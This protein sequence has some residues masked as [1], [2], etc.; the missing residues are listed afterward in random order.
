MAPAEAGA[1]Q[2]QYLCFAVVSPTRTHMNPRGMCAHSRASK[3]ILHTTA[4]RARVCSGDGQRAAGDGAEGRRRRRPDRVA[5]A[6]LRNHGAGD[7]SGHGAKGQ[8]GKDSRMH[9]SG[10]WI[11]A[12]WNRVRVRLIGRRGW[13]MGHGGKWAPAFRGWDGWSPIGRDVW[14]L[15]CPGGLEIEIEIGTLRSLVPAG[16]DHW[17][18]GEPRRRGRLSWGAWPGAH[19]LAHVLQARVRVGN[20]C[21]LETCAGWNPVRVGN[22]CGLETCAGWKRVRA[23]AR[24]WSPTARRPRRW[25]RVRS[26]T[27]AWACPSRGGAAIG[28]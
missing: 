14:D 24:W 21:G 1:A 16:L 4:C 8:R 27:C 28:T 3:R 25:M 18:R 23:R 7:P 22:V 12:G 13:P 20:V 11:R 5:R 26:W 2:C 9:V 19:A 15:R 17:N 10:G 6:L